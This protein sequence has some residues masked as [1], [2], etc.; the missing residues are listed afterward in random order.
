MGDGHLNKCK[1]C[2]KGDSKKREL[3]LVKDPVWHA[4]EK[5]R[6]REKYFRLGYKEKHKQSYEAQSKRRENYAKNH[7]EKY[8][9]KCRSGREKKEGFEKHHWSYNDDHFMDFMWL[10]NKDHNKLHRY[11]TYSKKDFMYRTMGGTLLDTRKK[12][13]DYWLAVKDLI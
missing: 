12:H 2:T 13:F 11:L 1:E 4:K 10:T 8:K 5:K 3:E 7:P 9:A 6:Q